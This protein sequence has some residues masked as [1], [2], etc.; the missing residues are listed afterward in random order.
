MINN[1]QCA[2]CKTFDIRERSV[3]YGRGSELL[4]H[5]PLYYFGSGPYEPQYASVYFCGAHCA[6]RYH[7]ETRDAEKRTDERP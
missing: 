1:I 6:N 4:G 5:W 2:Q 7:Q 3:Y